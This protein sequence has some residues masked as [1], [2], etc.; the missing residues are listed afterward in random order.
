MTE[1]FIFK[2]HKPKTDQETLERST[3][4]GLSYIRREM[5]QWAGNIILKSVFMGMIK[6]FQKCDV[7][8]SLPP[9]LVTNCHTFSDP[10]LPVERDVL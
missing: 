4:F 3:Q 2:V 9:P 1:I 8:S 6:E 5:R 10:S 7:T